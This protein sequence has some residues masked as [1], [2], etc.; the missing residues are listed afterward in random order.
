VLRLGAE[1][2]TPE[3]TGY[4]LCFTARAHYLAGDAGR[5]LACAR[6]ADTISRALVEHL[7]LAARVHLASAHAHLADGRAGD[8]VESARSALDLLQRTDKARAGEAATTLAAALL[9][10]ADLSAALSAAEEAIALCR[11]S[12]RAHHEAVAHGVLARALLR[13]DGAT[14][15]DAA[16]AALADAAA[17]IERTGAKTLAPALCEWRAELANVLGDDATRKQLLQEARRGYDEIGAPGHAGR[18]RRQLS[19][20]GQQRDG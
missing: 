3:L 5:A 2:G 8:A 17:R 6:Q 14:A 1:D 9:D 7:G 13:R 16:A 4:V 19:I 20:D 11:R 12:L 10:A 18:I 15:R